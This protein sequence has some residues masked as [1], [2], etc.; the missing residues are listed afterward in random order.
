MIGDRLRH[1]DA[2]ARSYLT[3]AAGAVEGIECILRARPLGGD[4]VNWVPR[5]WNQGVDNLAKLGAMSVN[6]VSRSISELQLSPDNQSW[7]SQMRTWAIRAMLAWDG[8]LL[9][10]AVATSSSLVLPMC[11]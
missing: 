11:F 1:L 3:A 10:H 6:F 8:S 2:G 7:F 9:V 4:V 5:K